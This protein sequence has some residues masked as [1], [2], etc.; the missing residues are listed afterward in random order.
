VKLW[1]AG[2]SC[3]AAPALCALFLL[4]SRAATQPPLDA[5][6]P[7]YVIADRICGHDY[8]VESQGLKNCTRSTEGG[9]HVNQ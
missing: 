9:A 5:A 6:A 4:R 2:A 7:G 8:H 3:C 1:T